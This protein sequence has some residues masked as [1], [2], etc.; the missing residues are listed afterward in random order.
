MSFLFLDLISP[1]LHGQT[2]QKWFSDSWT[3]TLITCGPFAVRPKPWTISPISSVAER[4]FLPGRQGKFA[5][6][7]CCFVRRTEERQNLNLSCTWSFLVSSHTAR[8]IR[9]RRTHCYLAK[10]QLEV[11]VVA[12]RLTVL[13]I[14]RQRQ[15][16]APT[17]LKKRK[18]FRLVLSQVGICALA[19]GLAR[20]YV[21]RQGRTKYP[22]DSST[23]ER[24]LGESAIGSLSLSAVPFA[25]KEGKWEY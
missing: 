12:K 7:R 6:G 1:I 10:H 13:I 2:L 23:G 16:T 9:C 24:P 20:R 8:P 4:A 17:G 15:W 5:S 25:T 11:N 14:F 18:W 19:S 3:Y 22:T 21:Q